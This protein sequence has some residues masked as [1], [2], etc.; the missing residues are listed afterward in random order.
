MRPKD[1]QRFISKVKKTNNCWEWTGKKDRDGYG[2]FW[3]QKKHIRAHRFSHELFKGDIPEGMQLDHLCRN[4]ACVNPEHLEVVT[5]QEN[6]KRGLTG[7]INHWRKQFTQCP[8]GHEYTQGKIQRI[9]KTCKNKA[10]QKLRLK[11]K[12]ESL[13]N[14]RSN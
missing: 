6:I 4:R 2:K 11:I 13:N 10:N 12:M 3:A 8:Y 5:L 9:C 1:I 14:T 7:K